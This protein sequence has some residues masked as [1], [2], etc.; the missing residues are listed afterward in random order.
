[1]LNIVR[2]CGSHSVV[3]RPCKAGR[4]QRHLKIPTPRMRSLPLDAIAF[5]NQ[6]ERKM[7]VSSSS[8]SRTS[9]AL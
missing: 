7:K 8:G 3:Q 9:I 6:L 4:V 1:M 5:T 2:V